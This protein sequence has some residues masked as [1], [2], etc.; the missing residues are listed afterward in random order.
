MIPSVQWRRPGPIG[1]ASVVVARALG[2]EHVWV[3]G[4]AKDKAR[5]RLAIELGADETFIAGPDLRESLAERTGGQGVD[6][7]LDVSGA[8]AATAEAPL[9]VRRQGTIVLAGLSGGLAA[10]LPA[11]L[12][13]INEITIKGVFSHD[14]SAVQ[15]GLT[16]ATERREIFDPFVTHRFSLDDTVDAIEIV[17]SSDGDLIKSVVVP[18][19]A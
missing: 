6:V 18:E 15:R 16:F 4:L 17:G 7:V 12:V 19:T 8:P 5:L 10:A 2:A 3:S 11:D 9:L 13:A 1:L 14:R